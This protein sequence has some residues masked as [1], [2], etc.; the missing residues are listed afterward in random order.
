MKKKRFTYIKKQHFNNCEDCPFF[1][2]IDDDYSPTHYQ[3][4]ITKYD[5]KTFTNDGS[6]DF[7]NED[8]VLDNC[9]FL[10]N[11]TIEETF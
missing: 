2:F 6:E 5:I 3:C 4:G 11:Q 1:F 7:R 9:P 8:G 10:K